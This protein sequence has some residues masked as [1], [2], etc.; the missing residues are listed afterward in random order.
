MNDSDLGGFFRGHAKVGL[1]H[2]DFQASLFGQRVFDV[3]IVERLRTKFGKDKCA[4]EETNNYISAVISGDLLEQALNLSSMTLDQLKGGT[5]LPWL[6]LPQGARLWCLYGRHRVEAAKRG[7]LLP[8]D[9][10]WSV[11]L[12]HDDLPDNLR[13]RLCLYRDPEFSSGDVFRNLRHCELSGLPEVTFWES[14]VSARSQ[15]DLRR[16][17]SEYPNIL[18]YLDRLIVFPGLWVDF[19]FTLLRRIV[20][21]GCP[22]E[23][24]RFLSHIQKI[25]SGLFPDETSSVD[26]QSVRLLANLMP[27]WSTTDR[28]EV[29]QLMDDGT[30]F[31]DVREG[32]ARDDLLHKLINVRGRVLTVHSLTQDTLLWHPCAKALKQ[33]VPRRGTDLRHAIMTQFAGSGIEWPVQ[34]AES[35]IE[36]VVVDMRDQHQFHSGRANAAYVQLWCFAIRH[37][38]SLTGTKL[39]ARK[40]ITLS[41]PHALRQ[42]Q[43]EANH[44]LGLLAKQ[45]G[46]WSPQ[47]DSLCADANLKPNVKAYLLGRRPKNIYAHPDRWEEKAS[48]KVVDLLKELEERTDYHVVSP[49]LTTEGIPPKRCGLPS[50]T[51]HQKDRASLYLP[52]IYTYSKS[53]G[54]N[55]SSF[56]ILRDMIF[57]FLGEDIFPA[58]FCPPWGPSSPVA[59]EP[60]PPG[61]PLTPIHED[62]PMEESLCLQREDP[63][64]EGPERQLLDELTPSQDIVVWPPLAEGFEDDSH[65]APLGTLT[66]IL[67][68]R[69]ADRIL[70]AWFESHN[71]S[72]AVFYLFKTRQYCKFALEDSNLHDKVGK[73]VDSLANDHFFADIHSGLLN[74]DDVADI[75]KSIRLVLV[76]TELEHHQPA[77]ANFRDYVC[78][79]DRVTGKRTF[80]D[81][82]ESDSEPVQKRLA[83][84]EANDT[85]E[86]L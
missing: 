10:W 82:E 44:R 32:T 30:L 28:S 45:L 43:R 63:E 12:Y 2:L 48:R 57:T 81:Q 66:E 71:T 14:M 21:M 58:E 47:V 80:R 86:E 35:V 85:E 72:L 36:Y 67:H 76:Y 84:A 4:R 1:E 13:R 34:V 39:P 55:P 33:L 5:G 77:T 78:S 8:G 40:D 29:T 46:F 74:P 73:F 62:Y 51:S 19:C 23:T 68:H 53:E 25:W 24:V 7:V 17:K 69:G 11:T 83:P 31:P 20:E 16:L 59:L 79:F 9:R 49:P 65:I 3:S 64:E 42:T 52:C 22:K 61:T 26:A 27:Q 75:I 38:E 18:R 6:V 54:D 37:I 41:D 70:N 15:K 56:N 60:H 50:F